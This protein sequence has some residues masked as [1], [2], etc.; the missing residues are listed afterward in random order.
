MLPVV[1]VLAK[2]QLRWPT[3]LWRRAAS[4]G[5]AS[6]APTAESA[7]VSPS[8]KAVMSRLAVGRDGRV[9]MAQCDGSMICVEIRLA[10]PCLT[11]GGVSDEWH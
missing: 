3:S 9:P 5:P 10:G 4:N 6:A 11:R 7:G 2:D 1:F 8:G